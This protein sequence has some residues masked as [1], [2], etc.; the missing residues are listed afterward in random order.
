MESEN[1]PKKF[2]PFSVD[3]LLATKVKL[4]QSENNNE[5]IN[6]SEKEAVDLSLSK[7]QI[8]KKEEEHQEDEYDED[9]LEDIAD[10]NCDNSDE[11]EAK[12][13]EFSAAGHPILNPH[14]RFPLGLGLPLPPVPTSSWNP[15]NP[16]MPQFRSPL[17]PFLPRK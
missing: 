11:D 12:E 17:N 2:S 6:S 1:K 16:W 10:E 15:V 7:L 9:D 3:S 8:P 4:Q 13:E 14:P 5:D